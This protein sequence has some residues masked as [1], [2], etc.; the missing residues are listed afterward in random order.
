[1]KIR[2][3]VR[4][5]EDAAAAQ[6]P[7]LAPGVVP[8]T[9]APLGGVEEAFVQLLAQGQRDGETLHVEADAACR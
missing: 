5:E 8:E 7:S 4:C 6:W 3:G 2:E 1:M 9:G